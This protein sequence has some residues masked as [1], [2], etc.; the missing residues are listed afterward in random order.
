MTVLGQIKIEDIEPKAARAFKAVGKIG[1]I[2]TREVNGGYTQGAV[3]L[4]YDLGGSNRTFVARFNLKQEWLTPQYKAKVRSGN[5]PENEATQYQINVEGLLRGLFTGAVVS[6]GTMDFAQLSGKTIGFGT[7][8]RK[9]DP[10]R[11]DIA[12]FFTPR[13]NATAR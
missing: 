8:T 10:S 3:P 11:L 12:S 2:E 9:N 7:R 6:A 5:V 4:T 13:A 1:T